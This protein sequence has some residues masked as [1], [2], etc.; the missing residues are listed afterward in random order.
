MGPLRGR[1]VLDFSTL[2]PGPMAT[3][4]LAEA[5]AEVVKIERPGTGDE[6]RT[7]QP[8]LGNDSTNFVLLNRGKRSV[9]LDLKDAAARDRLL[10]L[11]RRADVLVEQFR[12]GVMTRLG[13]SYADVSALNPGIIY[14]S[15]TGY[16]QSG[17]ASAV[18]GHDLNYLAET[19]LLALSHG[20]P[21]QPVIP[22]ALIADI[23][24]GAY[25]AVMNILL[26]LAARERNGKGCHLDVSMSD[27]L[28]P[29]LYWAMGQGTATGQWPGNGTDLVTGGTARY[30]LYPTADGG[31]IAAAPIEDRFWAS[32]CKAI[33][34]PEALRDGTA[35]I[36]TVSRIIAGQTTE[37]WRRVFAQADCCCCPIASLQEAME[38]PH[39]RSRGLFSHRVAA[40]D[41]EMVALP[42]PI[43]SHFRPAPDAAVSSPA[44]GAD[45]DRLLA[46]T[47]P[48]RQA[49]A[50]GNGAT[51][52]VDTAG[53]GPIPL[54][55]IHGYSLSLKTW[56]RVVG[57]FPASRYTT[58]RYDLRGF[59]TSSKPEAGYTMAQHVADLRL[60]L[61]RLEIAKAVLIGHSLGGAITQEFALEH[62]NRLL[63]YVS[64]N[65]YARFNP[66]PG[67]SPA[68]QQ[69]ADSFGT[70]EQNRPLLEGSVVRYLDPRNATPADLAALF[71]MTQNASSKALRDGLIDVYTGPT[72]DAAKYAAL[73]I[74]VLSI[75]GT[76]DA[77]VP[78]AQAVALSELI[79]D[80][81]LALIPR[82]GHSPMW[83]RS[84]AW[85]GAVLDFLSRRVTEALP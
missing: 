70:P 45:T 33:E 66:L 50:L 5:G 20:S 17:P 4:I 8:A 15:I 42:V 60:L 56:D 19:G 71:A 41:A 29:F 1:L 3:L 80:S 78:I 9:A 49:V 79:P 32:F 55:F 83:E 27:N 26:A 51:L 61:D 82:A 67:L 36:G 58:I 12:P 38:N 40:G 81:E 77:V 74:P 64:S 48:G 10:P 47:P 73:A 43:A 53:D 57:R 18:A 22:P 59:G 24:G 69:R 72:L 52:A 35:T 7:Y 76:T 2:L 37:H 84:E 65:A 25:P 31:I 11:L 30:R 46:Q 21:A 23:A 85:T 34:L 28:F 16:G 54:V 68:A 63:G 75:T 14:C 13:L 62:P 6:M 44:L 39:F